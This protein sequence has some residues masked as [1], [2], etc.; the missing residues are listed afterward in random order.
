MFKRLE[1]GG[2]VIVKGWWEATWEEICIINVYAP[3]C[4]DGKR[5]LWDNLGL[6]LSQSSGVAAC[7][8]GDFNSILDTGERSG[9]GWRMSSREISEFKDFVEENSLQDL[10]LQGRKYTWYMSNGKCKSRIDRALINDKW[11]ETWSDSGLRGLPRTIS[12]HCAIIMQ[13]KHEDWGVKPFRFV[14]AWLSH[15]QFREVVEKSWREGG[16]AGWGGYVVKE[17]LKCLKED[18]KRWNRDHFGHIDNKIQV[19]REEI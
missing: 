6:V 19:V 12:D 14:N 15:P 1:S 7:L 16:L 10:G 2:A 18:L 8:I 3:C 17:K 11:A 13:T 4:R 5:I 9:L